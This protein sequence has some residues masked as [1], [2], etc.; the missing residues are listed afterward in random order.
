MEI[1]QKNDTVEIRGN[2]KSDIHFHSIRMNVDEI[3]QQY[4]RVRIELVDS[5]SLTS[6]LIGYLT[7]IALRDGKPVE[8]HVGNASVIELLDDLNLLDVFTVKQRQLR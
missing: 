3:V 7:R 6:S 2:V 8:L 4:G 1:K 5:I